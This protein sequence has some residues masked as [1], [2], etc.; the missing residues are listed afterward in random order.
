MALSKLPPVTWPTSAGLHVSVTNP[1]TISYHDK[2]GEHSVTYY[3]NFDYAKI[4]NNI[5]TE[6]A[7]EIKDSNRVEGFYEIKND[8]RVEYRS[9]PASLI[10]NVNFSSRLAKCFKIN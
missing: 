9:L 2:K 5:S 8:G 1:R 3:Q 4:F 6:F 7:Q 10:H